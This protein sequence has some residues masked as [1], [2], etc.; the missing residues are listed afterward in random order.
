MNKT[1]NPGKLRGRIRA[2]SSKSHGH[3]LLICAALADRPSEIFCPQTSADLDATVRCLNALG[4]NIDYVNQTYYVQPLSQPR[5]ALLDCGESGS[6]LRFLLPVVAALGC[7]GEF[8]LRGRLPQRPLSPLQELLEEKGIELTR[9]QKDRLLLR[10]KLRGGDL[11]IGGNISSQFITGLL[12]A[13]PLLEEDSAIRLTS[14]LE[15]APYVE[16]TLSV[17]RL[18]GLRMPPYHG[19]WLIPGGLSYRSP[20]RLQAEGDWSNAAFW[21]CAGAICDTV[22]V[23]GLDPNS[24]QGDRAILSILEQF[25]AKLQ[26]EGDILR[27]SP[28]Q[29]R[30]IELDARQIPDLV[31]PV[32]LLA[33]CAEG[34]TRIRGAERLRLKES[35]RLESICGALR[36]LGGRAEVTEEGL[37]IYGGKLFGGRVRSCNDHRIAMLGAVASSVCSASVMIIGA[38]AVEKSYPDFWEDL[39]SLQVER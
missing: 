5:F 35:D 14:P 16:L 2:V 30:G 32:A 20:G 25:G 13:L 4:A 18:F 29:L 8:L 26:W 11:A 28:G 36:S 7:G 34:C 10:G 27:V 1:L 23:E 19:G 37:E 3:R 12:L 38:E 9:P 17:L 6:T 22:E 21:L 24:T 39:E 33:A 15:S 31:P